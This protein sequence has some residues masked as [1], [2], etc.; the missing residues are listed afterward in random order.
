[1]RASRRSACSRDSRTRMPAPSLHTNPS[2]SASNGR[3]ARSGSSLRVVMALTAQKPAMVRGMMMASAP[4]AIITSASPRW[5]IRK[6]SPM[7]WLPVAQ[8]VAADDRADQ[9]SE[10]RGVDLA[11]VEGGV[12]DGEGGRRDRVLQ[13][14]IE[15]AGFLLVDEVQ[16]VEVA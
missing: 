1:M 10:A 14:G 16:G 7:A 13:I 5:M 6:A 3:D 15:P 8:A 12:L 11:G 2:R 9:D 4:P